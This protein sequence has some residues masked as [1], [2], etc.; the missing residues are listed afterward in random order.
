[1]EWIMPEKKP[2]TPA[3]RQS[4]ARIEPKMIAAYK[5]NDNIVSASIYLIL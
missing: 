2:T 5:K 4:T 1:M 3:M